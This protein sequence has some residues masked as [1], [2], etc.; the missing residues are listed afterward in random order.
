[1]VTTQNSSTDAKK[2]KHIVFS[3][4][5]EEEETVSLD[6][7]EEEEEEETDDGESET[8]TETDIV[9]DSDGLGESLD[10]CEPPIMTSEK[11]VDERTVS[12]I[13]TVN[14]NVPVTTSGSGETATYVMMLTFGVVTV[15]S[16]L[17]CLGMAYFNDRCYSSKL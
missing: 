4:A 17:C 9:S 1:M 8:E 14:V 11:T 10:S 15:A 12:T 2:G 6:S 16:S 7:E 5:E 13:N 3:D